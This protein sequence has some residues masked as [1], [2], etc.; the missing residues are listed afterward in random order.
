LILSSLITGIA[1]SLLKDSII[2][3]SKKF[4]QKNFE[5]RLQ[6]IFYESVGDFKKLSKYSAQDDK[7][8]YNFQD[9]LEPLLQ[10]SFH[11]DF[12]QEKINSAINNNDKIIKPTTEELNKFLEIFRSKLKLDENLKKIEL[13]EKGLEIII[14]KVDEIK[15]A[16]SELRNDVKKIIPIDNKIPHCLTAIPHNLTEN[17]LGRE[18]DLKELEELLNKCSTVLV[19]NGM[20]GIGKSTLAQEYTKRNHNKFNHVAY[21]EVPTEFNSLEPKDDSYTLFSA[22][23][24]DKDSSLV[25][26]LNISFEDKTPLEEKFYIILNRLR[27]L[28]GNNL[29]VIDN[30]SN[31]LERYAN[32]LP[33]PPAWKV[34]VTSRQKMGGFKE[35]DL[36]VLDEEPARQLF[37][38]YYNIERDDKT[39]DEILFSIGRHT[40]TIELLAKTCSA[41]G[42]KINELK[43]LIEK[44]GLDLRS[45]KAKVNVRH[46]NTKP[47]GQELFEH[48]LGT[49]VIDF[50]EDCKTILRYF[51]VLPSVNIIYSDLKEIFAITEEDDNKFFENLE[52]LFNNGW[53]IKAENTYRCH[54]VIQE[55]A[56]KQL[57]PDE[58]NCA[59]LINSIGGLLS[60]DQTKDNPI[61]KF[62]WIIY[63]SAAITHF[64]IE[65]TNATTLAN[66]LALRLQNQGYYSQAKELMQ[67]VMELAIKNFGDKHPSIAIRS[68]NLALILRY[69]RELNK[70]KELMQKAM[71][72]AIKNF[73]EEHP[74]TA[75]IRS[76]LAMI[77]KDL[78]ELNKAKE[79]MQK[80]MDANIKNFGDDHPSTAIR[81]SNLALVLIDL[82][83][84]N[85]AKELMQKAMES[86]IKNFGDDH[87]STAIIRSNLATILYDLEELEKAKELITKA[88]LFYNNNLGEDHPTTKIVKRNMDIIFSKK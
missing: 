20:G 17:V 36:S 39:V 71:D 31:V 32:K 82:G 72:S 29:L 84:L 8:F 7:A 13:N 41:R 25:D 33:Q 22:F 77:L 65:T 49:F 44:E 69:L 23:A 60:V 34:I 75:I 40:L 68:S 53:L 1:T 57:K 14:E 6:N 43:K 45:A 19:V 51:S 56:R 50:D 73:G 3:Y 4:T 2:S 12:S 21:I 11:K 62:K 76:N 52:K 66:N 86:D 35:Y 67:K 55:V 46:G 54:Q 83:E 16:V 28:E 88:Y 70:A 27:N 74:S 79:L 80:A 38:E 58:K 42:R 87:P 81:H 18:K 63:G 30:V 24:E 5:D 10:F 48:L 15:E 26:N 64:S 37:Y 9:I 85:K 59:Y 78:G 61:D 47:G